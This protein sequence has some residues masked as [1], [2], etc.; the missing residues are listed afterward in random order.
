MA[1]EL[2]VLKDKT[3]LNQQ[4][5]AGRCVSN[6]LTSCGEAIISNS[7]NLNLLDL[8]NI[9]LKLFDIWECKPT[10]LNY[11]GFPSPLCLS[12]NKELV[13]G[14]VRD[15]TLQ[16]GDVI[17]VDVGATYKSAIAD[18][19]RTWIYGDPISKQHVEILDICKK[20]LI[21]GQNVVKVGN[22]IGAIGNAI[23]KTVNRTNYK[24][25]VDYGGH[26]LCELS[27]DEEPKLHTAPFIG[28]KQDKNDGIK[29]SNGLSIA[30][31]PMVVI[32][33]N[34]TKTKAGDF[35]V[36]TEN[37]GCHFE[38]SVTLF[39]DELHIITETPRFG[40]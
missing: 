39:E 23:Y 14:I 24:L 33:S 28:N 11:G 13:H 19:A 1:S 17:S 10:F 29:I 35:T 15:Y 31:E 22:R 8:E 38:N 27:S 36:Y 40:I 21:A 7:P 16:P 5:H 12:V 37:I 2:I 18:A 26:G 32:G 20:A 9:A 30:I 4:K 6:I 25:I 34:K 3:W